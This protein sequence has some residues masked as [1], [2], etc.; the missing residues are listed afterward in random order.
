MAGK[1]TNT[2]KKREREESKRRKKIAKEAKK[3]ERKEIKAEK[4]GELDDFD[5]DIANI[6]PGP[7]PR[8]GGE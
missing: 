6:I 2:F 7:Q 3:T 4:K 8:E 1:T 5:P